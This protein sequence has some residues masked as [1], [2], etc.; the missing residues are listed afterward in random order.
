MDIGID[1]IQRLMWTR[2]HVDIFT[3]MYIV[4]DIDQILENK[5]G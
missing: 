5:D 3:S 1:E 2:V 4:T